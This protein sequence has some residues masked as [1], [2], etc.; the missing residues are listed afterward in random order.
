M[1]GVTGPKPT[2][3]ITISSPGLAGREARPW[4]ARTGRANVP[5]ENSA[6]RCWNPPIL[7]HGG[8]SRHGS[9]TFTGTAKGA[10]VP[11][12]VVTTTGSGPTAVL[13]GARGHLLVGG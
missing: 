1:S 8:A 9:V 10:L 13:D 2:P 4:M 12:G 3:Y 7:N 5:S 11:P 6:S